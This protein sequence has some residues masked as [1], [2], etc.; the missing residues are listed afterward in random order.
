MTLTL[1]E[2][3][4]EK[5]ALTLSHPTFD[6]LVQK[7]IQSFSKVQLTQLRKDFHA[8]LRMTLSQ[9][10]QSELV[11]DLWDYFYDWCLFE[12]KLPDTIDSFTGDEKARW[13]LIKVN[14]YRGL[15]GVSR[16]ADKNLKIKDMLSGNTYLIEKQNNHD[17]V[18]INRGDILEARLFSEGEEKKKKTYFIRKPSYHQLEV[19]EYIRARVK[20]FKKSQDLASYQSWLWILVGMYLKHRIYAHMPIDK[21]YD[22]N[23]R[24]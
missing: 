16:V 24:I 10:E 18:G 12:Q 14:N 13:E 23:S 2:N 6:F 3:K 11:E 4:N 21:I 8:R 5:T 19:H 15:F 1:P 20:H 7:I 17:F 9:P 22:D